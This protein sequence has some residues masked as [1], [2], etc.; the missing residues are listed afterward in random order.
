MY[1]FGYRYHFF[2]LRM[3]HR[4]KCSPSF[5]DFAYGDVIDDILQD[6]NYGADKLYIYD[7]SDNRY[8]CPSTMA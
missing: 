7:D 4:Y 1:T 5:Q 2:Q 8:T 6:G 3:Q